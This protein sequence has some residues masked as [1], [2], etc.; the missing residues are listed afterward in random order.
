MQTRYNYGMM[1]PSTPSPPRI[2]RS[3]E[4]GSPYT[5]KAASLTDFHVE[6]PLKYASAPTP[7]MRANMA[8]PGE[9]GF[10]E[11]MMQRENIGRLLV[12]HQRPSIVSGRIP[13]DS[14]ELVLFFRSKSGIT[15]SLDF[16][17]DVEHNTPPALDVLIAACVPVPTD[18]DTFTDRESLFYPPN[19]PLTTSLELSNHPILDAVRSSL[20]PNLPPGHYLTTLR[21]KLEVI[22]AGGRME[23]QPPPTDGR[24]ATI[25]IT[26]PVRFRGGSLIIH[27]AEGGFQKFHGR[28]GRNGDIEWTAF[29]C[30]CTYEVETLQKGCKLALSYSVLIRTFGP[31]GLYPDPLITPSDYFLDLLSPILNAHRGRRIAFYLTHTYGTDPSAVIADTVVPN[32][33][34]GDS[35]LYH[36]LKLF[37]LE[38]ELRYT[39]GGYV[40]PVD[41]TVEISDETPDSMRPPAMRGAFN[42]YGGAAGGS[43]DAEANMLRSRVEASGGMPLAETDILILGNLGIDTHVSKERVPFV[44]SGLLEKL[45]VN[46]LLVSYVA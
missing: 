19:L 28:G 2:N 14:S 31:S 22:P 6:R 37:K 21:D 15:H 41:R 10:S 30:D 35:L 13:V 38:P 26:L 24:A 9:P 5:Y 1:S 18:R 44:S 17:I 16:P 33:K 40:W 45:I 23:V 7:H 11:E 32:L 46:V 43:E 8:M 29:T 27:D 39:A 42:V 4:D 3:S 36:A 25:V 34:G 20:F 12:A